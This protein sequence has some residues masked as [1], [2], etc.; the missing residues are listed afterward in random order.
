VE[1]AHLNELKTLESTYWWLVAKRPLASS[2]LSR[3][4]LPPACVVEGGI[5]AGGNLL[6]WQSLGYEVFGLDILPE[7]I[8]N[9]RRRG[10]T[11]VYQHDLH[12]PWPV[13]ENSA[14]AVVLLDVL[15][16]LRDPVTALQRAAATLDDQGKI[17]FTVPAHPWLFSEWDERLG[18]FRRYSMPMLRSEVKQAGLRLLEARPWNAVSLPIAAVLRT[19]RR[20]FPTHAGAEFPRVSQS[21]NQCLTNIQEIERRYSIRGMPPFGLS[22]V[23]VIGK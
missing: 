6:H 19:Y 9:A 3:Y 17:I 2:L 14:Q 23:G 15:E 13:M 5:G 8:E 12:D 4:V 21:L 16:H 18:H 20:I 10:L 1:L 22:I 11:H 7:S